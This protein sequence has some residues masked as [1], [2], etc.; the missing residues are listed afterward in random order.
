MRYSAAFLLLIAFFSCKRDEPAVD[1]KASGYPATISKLMLSSCA[2]Q[3]CHTSA[4][5][6]A[7]AGLSL[8]TW[9]E[10]IQG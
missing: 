8:S 1:T 10:M 2:T 3:G 4:S 9:D 5:K 7:A 6:D